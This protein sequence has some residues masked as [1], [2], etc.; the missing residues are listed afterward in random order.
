MA[1]G[2]ECATSPYR[3]LAPEFS[4]FAGK[5]RP[6]SYVREFGKDAFEAA[7]K[8]AL[9]LSTYIIQHLS[10]SNNLQSQEDRVRFFE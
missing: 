2:N 4:V 10:E 3:Y 8:T 9:P 7:M 5:A 1:C 6:D